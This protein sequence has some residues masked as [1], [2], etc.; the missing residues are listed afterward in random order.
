[1]IFPTFEALLNKAGHISGF[2]DRARD[3]SYT[4]YFTSD[5]DSTWLIDD[6]EEKIL[7]RVTSDGVAYDSIGQYI[8][9][10]RLYGHGWGFY[11]AGGVGEGIETIYHDLLKAEREV[12]KQ[13]LGVA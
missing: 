4:H 8:G 1:M 13:L 5:D 12:F 10:F 3:K 9:S 11:P 7:Y 2:W 6:T